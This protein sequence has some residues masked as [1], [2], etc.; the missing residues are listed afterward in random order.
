MARVMGERNVSIHAQRT[1]SLGETSLKIAHA[2]AL[3]IAYHQISGCAIRPVS[4]W[5]D[6]DSINSDLILKAI[7]EAELEDN[8]DNASNVMDV[9]SAVLFGALHQDSNHPSIF[10]VSL[11]LRQ[12]GYFLV[13]IRWN[14][15]PAEGICPLTRT[16]VIAGRGYAPFLADRL[17][18]L[19][20]FAPNIRDLLMDLIFKSAENENTQTIA[21]YFVARQN[22][23]GGSA[24]TE[25]TPANELSIQ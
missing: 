23:D 13:E 1:R 3:A 22:Q 6:S 8:E 20:A 4:Q 16:G 9:A 21:G 25:P 15:L 24:I 7:I 2:A 5:D 18:S 14:E 10:E 17:V 19:E 11:M 12:A